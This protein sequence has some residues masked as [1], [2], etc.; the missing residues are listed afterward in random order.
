M[1][2][3]ARSRW[4]LSPASRMLFERSSATARS[5]EPPPSAP[6]TCAG[7]SAVMVRT[8]SA[9]EAFCIGTT[10][11]SASLS[12]SMRRMMRTMRLTLLARSES[13]SMFEEG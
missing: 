8:T 9:A 6:C 11:M 10:S 13:T 12:W 5:G 1:S 3:R 7:L 2:V 4:V